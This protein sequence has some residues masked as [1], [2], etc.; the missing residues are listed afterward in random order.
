MANNMFLN[1]KHLKR[2][3]F[4]L[5]VPTTSATGLILLGMIPMNN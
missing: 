4:L 3:A 5:L 2:L 1:F